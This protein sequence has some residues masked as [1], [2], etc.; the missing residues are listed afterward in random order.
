MRLIVA[1]GLTLVLLLSGLCLPCSAGE[2]DSLYSVYSEAIRRDDFSKAYDASMKIIEAASN[3]GDRRN[4][5]KAKSYLA[6]AY[7]SA[8]MYD[9]AYPVLESVEKEIRDDFGRDSSKEIRY[10]RYTIYNCL[11]VYALSREMDCEEAIRNFLTGMEYARQYDEDYIYE[12]LSSNLITTYLI[13]KDPMG[14]EP[15]LDMLEYSEKRNV[16]HLKY[17][18][19]YLVA[20]MYWLNKDYDKARFYVSRGLSMKGVESYSCRYS[21]YNLY[22]N[23]LA[24]DG[25]DKEAEEYYR[26][27]YQALDSTSL[28]ASSYICMCYGE[29]LL[30]RGRSAEASQVVFRGIGRT[31]QKNR[32]YL[33]DLLKLASEAY[34]MSGNCSGALDMYVRYH[35][36]CQYVS[37]IEKERASNN[38]IRKY[39]QEKYQD[40]IRRKT[41]VMAVSIIISMVILILL[42]LTL[43]QYRMKNRLYTKIVFQYKQA[44]MQH[45]QEKAEEAGPRPKDSDIDAAKADEIFLRMEDM[46]HSD[47]AY[48][49]GALTIDA[50]AQKLDTNRTYL[51]RII[52]ARTGLNFLQYINSMRIDRAILVLSDPDNDTP[53]KALCTELGYSSM[54]SFYN[55]FKEKVG[56]SPAKYREKAILISKTNNLAEMED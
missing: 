15:A 49:D 48:A 29:F 12:I 11:G 10:A 2:V 37:D 53:L 52:K 41:Q 34:R 33:A 54:T 14:L 1:A 6:Q 21:M 42:V 30:A 22:A 40:K 3:D 9:E 47:R 39:E 55:H 45:E 32:I 17:S 31:S 56:M 7:L 38:L 20:E 44:I 35:D 51:S 46:M 24:H 36:E 19:G 27:A 18:A 26:K 8:D 13:R 23:I 28:L 25:K 5:L 43:W 50:L 16:D 4:V